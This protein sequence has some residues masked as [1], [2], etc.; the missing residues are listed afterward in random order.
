MLRFEILLQA[1]G[2]DH[3][4]KKMITMEL[5]RCLLMMNSHPNIRKVMGKISMP[6]SMQLLTGN[7]KKLQ[8]RIMFC[9]KI[10]KYFL[11][12]YQLHFA[13][14]WIKN[15]TDYLFISL[16]VKWIPLGI[17]IITISLN[18]YIVVTLSTLTQRFFL[19]KQVL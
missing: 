18:Q 14:S 13:D 17:L 19:T 15:W 6:S 9:L 10:G 11:N 1:E 7:V 2:Q 12:L 4:R 16:S 5:L 8:R 3:F